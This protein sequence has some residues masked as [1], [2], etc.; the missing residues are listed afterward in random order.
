MTHINEK[1]TF[2]A[3]GWGW[4]WSGDPDR[5]FHGRQ[6][7]GWIFNIFP[8]SELKSVH[9]FGKNGNQKGRTLTAQ[10]LI[11]F[12]NCPTR[13][14][15]IL[16]P[17]TNDVVNIDKTGICAKADYAGN[18]GDNYTS[19]TSSGPGS[20]QD[21]DNW[22]AG[23]WKGQLYGDPNTSLGVFYVHGSIKLKDILVGTAHLYLAGEKYLNPDNVLTTGDN[24]DQPWSQGYDI[25]TV[26]WVNLPPQLDQRGVSS[27]SIF[28]SNHVSSFNMVFCDGAVH[29][30]SYDINATA[31]R[32]LG[33]R[34]GKYPDS[35]KPSGWAIL[36]PV[37]ASQYQ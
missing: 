1:G 31:H 15:L 6:P 12:F 37:D 11:P 30:I 4:W 27:P 16:Y 3:G 13:R 25:D 22:T 17:F 35:S 5:G 8:F 9:D 20:Y 19:Y 29:S 33:N 23:Q 21:G 32:A 10:S 14:S 18:G 7:G 2:P 24:N 26:R 34:K 28:G 36:P